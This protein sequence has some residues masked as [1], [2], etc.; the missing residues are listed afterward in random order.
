MSK[1][2]ERLVLAVDDDAKYLS[3]LKLSLR[4]CGFSKVY[5]A[6]DGISALNL[7]DEV[8]FSLIISDWNIAPMNGL[9][10]L[11]RVRQYPCTCNIPFIIMTSEVTEAAW[12]EAI[13]FRVS[14]FLIKP[15]TIATLR[16]SCRITYLPADLECSNIL[17]LHA[18]VRRQASEMNN[19]K[20]QEKIM[21]PFMYDGTDS[22][23]K[24]C[25]K[26]NIAGAMDFSTPNENFNI[27]TK[28]YNIA[29]NFIYMHKYK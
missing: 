17:P 9:E 4:T 26:K 6:R 22:T 15:F 19:I 2:Q 24:H 28:Y 23:T 8:P 21:P 12:R 25:E 11:K 5:I 10:L 20:L 18:Q 29:K 1:S 27:M 16:A 7:M 3:V 14:E 13:Q